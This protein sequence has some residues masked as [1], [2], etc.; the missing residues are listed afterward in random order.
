MIVTGTS[1]FASQFGI[2]LHSASSLLPDV[3][4]FFN[5]GAL[6]SPLMAIPASCP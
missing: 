3:L 6:R 4:K 2:S 5:P 1:L